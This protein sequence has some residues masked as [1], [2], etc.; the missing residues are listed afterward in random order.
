VS[1]ASGVHRTIAQARVWDV[2]WS[3][4]GSKI[5]FTT[6]ASGQRLWIVRLDGTPAR[7]VFFAEG[8]TD[9]PKW[10]PNSKSI[11]FGA[12]RRLDAPARVFALD[13]A[14]G[15]ATAL[16][17]PE[18]QEGSHSPSWSPDGLRLVYERE[19]IARSPHSESDVWVMNADGT[20]KLQLTSAFPSG[21]DTSAPEWFQG[22]DTS[23]LMRTRA[24]RSRH[25]RVESPN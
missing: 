6:N 18:F 23:S 8:G 9:T 15:A 21:T 20:A 1:V 24:A 19:R 3:P 4:D 2:A 17:V 12:E 10:S 13:V 25:G 14:S 22:S 16:T 5:A 11:A 7:S